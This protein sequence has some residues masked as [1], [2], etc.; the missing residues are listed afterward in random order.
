MTVLLRRPLGA[1]PSRRVKSE[2]PAPAH[3]TQDDHGHGRELA[4]K[5]LGVEFAR[6]QPGEIQIGLELGVELRMRA[7][8][9]IQCDDSLGVQAAGQALS[10]VNQDEKRVAS[11]RNVT[12]RPVVVSAPS[13]PFQFNG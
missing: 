11:G 1:V 8:D 9:G 5:V 12:R 7:V 13:F 4:H 2:Q 3:Q 10:S 6:G